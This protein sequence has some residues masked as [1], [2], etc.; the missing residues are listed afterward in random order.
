MIKQKIRKSDSRENENMFDKIDHMIE[1]AES[2]VNAN[3]YQ[4]K[5]Y[6]DKILQNLNLDDEEISM[7]HLKRLEYEKCMLGAW[8]I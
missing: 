1:E 8:A 6:K 3:P 4:V 5:Y 2:E 7:Y